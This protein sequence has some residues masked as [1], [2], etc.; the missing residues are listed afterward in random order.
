MSAQVYPLMTVDDPIVPE[1]GN[2]HE[3]IEGE[4]FVSRARWSSAPTGFGNIFGHF[5]FYSAE[6]IRPAQ[7]SPPRAESEPIQRVIPDLV[8][9]THQR[10]S[11][12]IA[13]HV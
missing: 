11:E 2:R 3:V 7:L 5:W 12:I 6:R 1:D 9:F 4:L 8:F 10:G 13:N